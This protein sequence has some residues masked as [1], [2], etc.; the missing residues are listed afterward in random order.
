[1]SKDFGTYYVVTEDQN[2][3]EL[4][5]GRYDIG[6]FSVKRCDFDDPK[7][8]YKEFTHWS[9]SAVDSLVFMD[10]KEANAVALR[11][12]T[13]KLRDVRNEEIFK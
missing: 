8:L 3:V 4:P 6:V 1:M 9:E 7:E 12:T 2:F 11:Y 10:E 13:E 5:Y